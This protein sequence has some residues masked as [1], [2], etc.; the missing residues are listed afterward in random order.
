MMD[1]GIPITTL[2]AKYRNGELSPIDV[3]KIELKKIHSMNKKVNPIAH[4]FDEQE[5]LRKAAE[6]AQRYKQNKT[7]GAFDGTDPL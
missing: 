7:L 4:M 5:I 1:T 2:T 6:S 3:V